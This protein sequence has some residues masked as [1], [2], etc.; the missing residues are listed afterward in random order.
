MGRYPFEMG[1]RGPYRRG[2]LVVKDDQFVKL[3]AGSRLFDIEGLRTA[4]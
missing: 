2:L 4:H 3:A 1:V